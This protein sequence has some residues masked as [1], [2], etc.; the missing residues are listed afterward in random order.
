MK[1]PLQAAVLAAILA[2]PLCAL[3]DDATETPATL[4]PVLVTATRSDQ[5]Q[6][7][8]PTSV[9]VITHDE[10][11]ASGAV[12]IV[13]VLRGVAGAQVTDLYGDGTQATVDF[14]G[15]G[16]TAGSNTLVLVDGRRLNNPDIGSP[17]LSSVSIKDIERI[18]IIHG[19]AG[20]LYG[21]QAVGGVINIITRKP[22][23]LAADAE[24][25]L[26]SYRGKQARASVA[27]TLGDFSFRLS[28]EGRGSDN[29][30]AN[31]FGEYENGLARA[32]YDY[33]SGS[34]FV[35]WTYVNER[36]QTPGALTTAEMQA[37]PRQSDPD[38][39][40]N[41]SNERTG[42]QR[43]NWK[44]SLSSD[45]QIETD[46]SH[47]HSAGV[48]ELSFIG[49][50]AT[51][52]STQDRNI[53]SINPRV[54][55]SFDFPAGKAAVTAGIDAQHAEYALQSQFG[56]Q[57]NDQ[58]LR[59]VY[60]QLTLPVWR[61]LEATVGARTAR[62]DND[63]YDGF[64]FTTPTNF[65]D[66]RNALEGGL[67]IRP[68]QHLR[69]FTRYDSNFRFAKVDEFTDDGAAPA[70][71]QNLLQ[72]QHGASY[73]MGGEW[74]ANVWTFRTTLYRLQLH[75]EIVF[76][77]NSFTNINLP[78]TRR[79][80]LTVE[81]DW[82]ALKALKLSASYG[83][84]D[85]QIDSG[86]LD[87]K[88]VPLAARNIGRVAAT[89]S[90]PWQFSAYAETL[91]TGARRYSGDYTNS[92]GYLPGYAVVNLTLNK[93]FAQN[94]RASFRLNNLLDQQYSEYGT[95][96]GTTPYFY[97]SPGRN[98]WLNLAYSL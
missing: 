76:D 71:N 12:N 79:D 62:V 81:T 77:P 64:T 78:S 55:G 57:T 25:G 51:S 19:S 83:F 24:A 33:G 21:D 80:G 22:D 17:D 2:V 34:T 11:V 45:W 30:R 27:D 93:A 31:D 84:M 52:S 74:T 59:D 88:Q 42:E 15:F 66:T 94:W 90:L 61:T 9:T 82:Q 58:R 26:G 46:L 92:A 89:A 10:I 3:A 54:T 72:T 35:E 41:F 73:E 63:V 91:A 85:A 14:R 16:D 18:E 36:Q 4:E 50:P 20:A 44:Q 65:S 37:D 47:R 23:G 87:G 96:S 60:T 75:N 70:S 68:L 56:L 43:I 53:W 1:T 5:N 48:F 29:Y 7:R 32:G 40:G 98:F 8:L 97:P 6:N 49:F 86:D 67:S 38:Y 28:G 39:L 95:A 69:L 13:Q